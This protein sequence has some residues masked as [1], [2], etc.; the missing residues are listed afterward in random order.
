MS[1]EQKM[2]R[3]FH[4]KYGCMI[5]DKPTLVDDRTLLLRCRLLSEEVSEFI[6]AASNHDLVELSDAMGDIMVVLLG[7]AVVL[8]IDLE[9][10]FAE[11]HKSNMSKT[12]GH[13]S[14]G[15]VS[16]GPDFV[17]PDIEGELRKQGYDPLKER[18]EY[19]QQKENCSGRFE[20]EEGTVLGCSGPSNPQ[21]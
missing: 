3:D 16:K 1:H 10:I 19:F 2:V 4:E 15:K 5:N 13:D 20:S 6:A 8:G 9:P 12:G 14:G 18:T 17:P 7:A 11:I 21:V